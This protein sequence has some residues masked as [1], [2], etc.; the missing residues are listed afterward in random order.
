MGK[1]ERQARYYVRHREQVLN[2]NKRWAELNAERKWGTELAR[3]RTN[4][5]RAVQALGCH[6]VDCGFD[7]E[8][9]EECAQFDHLP[10]FEKQDNMANLLKGNYEKALVELAKCE[11]VCANCHATRTKERSIEFTA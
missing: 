7:F 3:R 1:K 8:G 6:C 11:L 9:R 2:S 10:G 5:V 4:K